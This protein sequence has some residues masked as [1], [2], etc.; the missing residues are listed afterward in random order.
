MRNYQAFDKVAD[1]VYMVT[2]LVV[3][4]RWKG[5]PR[6]VAL[7]LFAYRA[8]GVVYFE[9]VSPWRVVLLFFPNVFEFWFLL[10]AGMNR[11]KP[12]YEATWKRAALWIP[13]LIVLKAFQEYVLHWGKWLDNY[14]AV[15][16]V[17]DWW[18]AVTFLFQ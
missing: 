7:V 13:P 1:H 14:R 10:I 15:D 9:F 4:L 16:M 12:D 18:E 2:F 5:V 3:A 6:H 17:V 8:V 11:L